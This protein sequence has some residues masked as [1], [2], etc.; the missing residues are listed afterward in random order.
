M[1]SGGQ[2]AIFGTGAA[3]AEAEA[4]RVGVDVATARRVYAFLV[5]H[6]IAIHALSLV[7]TPL[8]PLPLHDELAQEGGL[9]WRHALEVRHAPLQTLW[10]AVC[11]K[12]APPG[13]DRAWFLSTFCELADEQLE[14]YKG[15]VKCPLC[16][17][18]DKDCLITKCG[19]AFCRDCI[20][21]RL[22]SRNRKCPSC[23]QVFGQDLV[24]S[25]FLSFGC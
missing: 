2:S 14:F 10:R 16:K 20:D 24:G 5:R 12:R 17:R 18:S 25:L 23:N 21:E 11:E 4:A 22:A 13:Q 9:V 7:A 8:V 1:K 3:E 15:M 6:R 19:H